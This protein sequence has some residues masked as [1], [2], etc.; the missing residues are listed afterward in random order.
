MEGEVKECV[1]ISKLILCLVFPGIT[2]GYPAD[3]V[4]GSY[5]LVNSS[6]SYLSQVLYTCREGY[7]M[8]GRA[9]LTCDVDERWNG[10]PP[11]CEPILCHEPPAIPHGRFSMSNNISIAGTIVEYSCESRRYRL[12]GSRKIV[13]LPI[14]QYDKAPPT[15]KEE[16]RT[17]TTP[18]PPPLGGLLGGIVKASP[19]PVTS[20]P[21][22]PRPRPTLPPIT[23]A[24]PTTRAPPPAEDYDD[25]E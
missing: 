10:P 1:S 2:C 4:D 18:A 17:T 8:V 14:G 21:T 15:C 23:R 6:V 22:T 12:V 3:I 16:I 5:Q 25:P 24:P 19:R 7:D 9:R 20:R 11:R 13:C